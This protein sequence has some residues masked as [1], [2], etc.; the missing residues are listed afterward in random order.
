[1]G[2]KE[3]EENELSKCKGYSRLLTECGGSKKKHQKNIR[4]RI[5]PIWL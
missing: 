1:M 4:R 2:G 5:H 3:N